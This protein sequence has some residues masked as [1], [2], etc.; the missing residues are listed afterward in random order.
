M[1]MEGGGGNEGGGEGELGI[2][3]REVGEVGVVGS[4]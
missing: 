2:E 3:A 1:K 4:I